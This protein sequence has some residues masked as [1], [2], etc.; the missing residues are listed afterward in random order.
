[1]GADTM[2]I[3]TVHIHLK[4]IFEAII[5]NHAERDNILLALV[6]ALNNAIIHGCGC[7]SEKQVAIDWEWNETGLVRI[8]VSD[9]GCFIP[10]ELG[11][12]PT[13]PPNDVMGGRGLY[14]ITHI[15]D[16]CNHEIS[17]NGHTFHMIK[18]IRL[19]H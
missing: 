19:D 8:A 18:Q 6:E 11:Q 10:K 12:T 4:R 3:P 2:L 7:V 16:E 15:M 14:L 9:P 17:H 1:M 13:L 5:T